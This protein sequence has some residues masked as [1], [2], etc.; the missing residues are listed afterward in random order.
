M[1]VVYEVDMVDG[2]TVR[3]DRRPVH[4]LRA[5]RLA[6]AADRQIGSQEELL[7]IIWSTITGGTGTIAEFDAWAD[8]V[9]DWRRVEAEDNPP[10]DG[11]GTSPD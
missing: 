2:S 7:L 3:G 10:A 9:A 6:L 11:S 1:A 4:L 5:E 8:Q